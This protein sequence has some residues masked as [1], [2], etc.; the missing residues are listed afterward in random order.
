MTTTPIGDL[1]QFIASRT[2]IAEAQRDLQRSSA[3]FASGRKSDLGTALRGDF[4]RLSTVERGLRLT[5]TYLAAGGLAAG[6]FDTMQRALDT[7]Q[8]Q[9]VE[10]G[11]ALLSASGTGQSKQLLT[12]ATGAEQGFALTIG[13]I[14]TQTGGRSPF[15][16]AATNALALRPAPDILADLDT[17]AA[18]APDAAT[19]IAD[20]EA[21]FMDA[22]GGYETN[23]Y[24]GSAAPQTGFTIGEDETVQT[25]ISALDPALRRTLS[26]LAL[27]ALM[28]R[29]VGPTDAASLSEMGQAAGR[30]MQEGNDATTDL[31]AGLGVL[32]QRVESSLTRNRALETALGQEQARLVAADPFEAATEL[33]AVETRLES[34]YL[35][36]SRLS[37]LSLAEYL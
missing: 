32:E 36:T 1:A 19:L 3:E 2:R 4:S 23:A 24:L 10:L 27:G 18:A 21:Y 11:P 31:R 13:A 35:L 8:S 37:R 30:W 14:N 26:G 17:L 7:A 12:V 15:A 20:V 6:Y 25:D 28:A 5:D 22:G 9:V 16:G 29:Q 33:Q 34:L